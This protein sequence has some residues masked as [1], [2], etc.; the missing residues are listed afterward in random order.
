MSWLRS[1]AY[2]LHSFWAVL[3]SSMVL[4]E[5]DKTSFAS[6][7]DQTYVS[8]ANQSK[9]KPSKD[10]DSWLAHSTLCAI[11]VCGQLDM[12][13]M[14]NGASKPLKEYEVMPLGINAGCESVLF[15][16]QLAKYS[17]PVVE[18]SLQVWNKR[19]PSVLT[20]NTS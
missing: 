11:N 1:N 17:I 16:V 20:W 19:I 9:P 8:L 10:F 15:A 12:R 13:Q 6:Q 4:S 5:S 7:S 2:Q 3:L 18:L 14:S